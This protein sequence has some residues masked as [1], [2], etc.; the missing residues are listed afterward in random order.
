MKHMDHCIDSLRQ[1][2][3]CS[4]DL[5]PIPYAWNTKYQQNMPI[6]A[7]THTCRDF[8]AI[9]EWARADERRAKAMDA[10]VRVDDPLGDVEY[11]PPDSLSM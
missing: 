4:S 9:K 10:H 11:T 3:M 8:E 7:T 5:A 6:A 1:S 2:L